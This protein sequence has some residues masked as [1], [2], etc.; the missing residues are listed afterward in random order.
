MSTTYPT[1]LVMQSPR[2]ADHFGRL[3]EE[4]PRFGV[5]QPKGSPAG[6]VIY[7]LGRDT[8]SDLERIQRLVSSGRAAEV[9]VTA[10]VKDPDL[11]IAAMRVGVTEFLPWPMEPA[12]LTAALNRF[13]ERRESSSARQPA[14]VAVGPKGRIIHVLGVKGGVG[15]TT[16]AVNLAVETARLDPSRPVAL[17]DAALPA[18]EIPLFLD[19][20]YTYTWA[21]AVRDVKRLDST[22][23]ESLMTRHGSGV[24][25]LAAPDRLEDTSSLSAEGMK[26][27]LELMRTMYGTVIVDGSPYL[28]PPSL[29]AMEAADEILLTTE[30]S[31]PCLSLVRRLLESFS[32]LDSNLESKTRLVVTRHQT[33]GGITPSEAEE[34]LGIKVHWL[35]DNDYSGT[36]EAINLGRPLYETAPK[37]LA[38]KSIVRLAARYTA[39][40]APR[41]GG[42]AG[43]LG[44]F[45][46]KKKDDAP[47]IPTGINLQAEG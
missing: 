33:K 19:F 41:P 3:V 31:L 37:S 28:D 40:Q 35:I 24:D 20:D 27:M 32:N 7:E 44:R 30:L 8:A 45:L 13:V 5:G 9:F 39:P 2:A 26:A 17:V 10:T 36:L 46:S 38:A 14:P 1:I 18:G 21:E 34:L 15:A 23:L 4:H 6:L 25:I 47:A 22:F 42:K 16:L 12:D 29:A 11:I 43:L